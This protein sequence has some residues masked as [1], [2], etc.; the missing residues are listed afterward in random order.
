MN[1]KLISELVSSD[2][3][4]LL[5]FYATEVWPGTET[6]LTAEIH[7]NE[8]F[9]PELGYTVYLR[10]MTGQKGGGVIILVNSKSTSELKSAYH[11]NCENLWVQLNL[12]GSKSV[13][14]GAYYKPHESDQARFEELIISLTLVNQTNST[15]WLL[16]DFNLPKVHWENLKPLPDCSHPFFT[17]VPRGTEGLSAWA[18][19]D[20]T[21]SGSKHFGLILYNKPY[22]RG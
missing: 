13:L 21:N 19:R 2:K 9:P 1:L 11:T 5:C 17:G 16:G 6:W 18:N 4:V 12:A 7:D 15:V 22:P 14:I 20:I 3:S 8:Y 10:D